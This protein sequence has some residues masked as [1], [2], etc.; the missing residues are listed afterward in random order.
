MEPK[1]AAYW[2]NVIHS[3]ILQRCKFGENDSYICKLIRNG[4]IEDFIISMNKNNISIFQFLR[5]IKS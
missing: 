2:I 3:K 5:Q 1:K 4:S